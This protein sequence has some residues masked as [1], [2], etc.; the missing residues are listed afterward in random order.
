MNRVQ[1]SAVRHHGNKWYMYNRI[2]L[3]MNPYVCERTAD[4]VAY[5]K[6]EL[7][8]QRTGAGNRHT[9]R[10]R[11]ILDRLTT[12]SLPLVTVGYDPAAAAFVVARN[13][14]YEQ[15]LPTMEAYMYMIEADGAPS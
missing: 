15:I 9:I 3:P 8:K 7:D 6:K 10:I 11:R 5:V 4:A 14:P 1:I 2:T 12:T 13:V